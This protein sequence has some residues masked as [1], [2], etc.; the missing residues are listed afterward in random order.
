MK[1]N[2]KILL[3]VVCLIFLVQIVAAERDI[4]GIWQLRAPGTSTG[5]TINTPGGTGTC[6]SFVMGDPDIHVTQSGTTLMASEGDGNGNPFTLDGVINGNSVAFTIQ[7]IGITPGF[8]PATTTYTGTLNKNV[9]TGS[10]SGSATSTFYDENG[11]SFTET[12]TWTGTFVT[13]V[14]STETS[15]PVSWT[16]T[17][18]G[19]ETWQES[20]NEDFVYT[21]V[22]P[23]PT[24]KLL[25]YQGSTGKLL[26]AAETGTSMGLFPGVLSAFNDYIIIYQNSNLV[27][28]RTSDGSKVWTVAEGSYVPTRIAADRE[29]F[30]T[31]SGGY[32]I[33]YRASDGARLLMKDISIPVGPILLIPSELT[34]NNGYIYTK[35]VGLGEDWLRKHDSNLNEIYRIDEMYH[36][37]MF[38]YGPKEWTASGSYLFAII[39][40]DTDTLLAKYQASNGALVWT[41]SILYPAGGNPRYSPDQLS[42]S[43]SYVFGT[44]LTETDDLLIKYRASD[45]SLI[46]KSKIWYP[47]T[48]NPRYA[49]MDISATFVST[50]IVHNAPVRATISGSNTVSYSEGIKD[51]GGFSATPIPSHGGVIS[52]ISYTLS[53]LNKKTVKILFSDTNTLITT[54]P[55]AH[56]LAQAQPKKETTSP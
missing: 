4:S 46:G 32:L 18:T 12:Y 38:G 15:Y 48:G 55:N 25:K 51:L 9:I 41:K 35:T 16:V 36:I 34:V 24:Y 31:L 19:T 6:G 47:P 53:G 5:C 42:A 28:Y 11:N 37:G 20:I 26:W 52:G 3:C 8:A 10:F 7:G 29:N 39:N 43:S 44:V 2:F 23:A 13:S 22:G 54:N 1:Q 14:V 33:K 45:G 40:I 27:K 21:V 17:G 30:Y 50:S 49:P 56:I